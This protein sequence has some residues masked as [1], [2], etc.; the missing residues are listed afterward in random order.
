[1]NYKVGDTV[2]IKKHK[3]GKCCNDCSTWVEQM[4]SFSG[5]HEITEVVES[6]KGIRYRLNDCFGYIFSKCMLESQKPLPFSYKLKL[7]TK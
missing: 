7:T 1:M 6:S 4:D 3:L 5:K 2:T